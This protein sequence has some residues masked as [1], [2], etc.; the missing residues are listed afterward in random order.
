[1]DYY[2]R[3]PNSQS[4]FNSFDKFELVSPNPNHSFNLI[5]CNDAS[6][7]MSERVGEA[8]HFYEE[9]LKADPV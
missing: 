7:C 4:Y 6:L 8:K 9:N 1:M 2:H 5:L 3:T